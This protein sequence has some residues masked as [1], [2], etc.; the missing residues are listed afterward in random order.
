MGRLAAVVGA[1]TS[2]GGTCQKGG[3]ST[4]LIEGKP[5]ILEQCD[6]HTGSRRHRGNPRVVAAVS[7]LTVDGLPLAAIGSTCACGCPIVEP[8]QSTVEVA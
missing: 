8:N 1:K 3:S 6:Y 2:C 4:L 5:A 7:W